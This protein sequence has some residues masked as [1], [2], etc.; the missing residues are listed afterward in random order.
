M[1]YL[2]KIEMF[3]PLDVDTLKELTT[4]LCAEDGSTDIRK[5]RYRSAIVIFLRNYCH[6]PMSAVADATRYFDPRTMSKSMHQS[7]DSSLHSFIYETMESYK[8]IADKYY[9]VNSFFMDRG[10]FPVS[11]HDAVLYKAAKKMPHK[12]RDYGAAPNYR[13][14]PNSPTPMYCL[15]SLITDYKSNM[16]ILDLVD[17]YNIDEKTN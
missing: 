9:G 15:S 14:T 13:S 11:L 4:D 7:W 16:P 3:K 10:S 5:C 17:K 2:D 12:M 6:L 1:T 8:S